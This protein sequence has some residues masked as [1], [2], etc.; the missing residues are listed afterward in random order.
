MGGHRCIS[1][2]RR[3]GLT[4]LNDLKRL[5]PRHY[6]IIDLSLAGMTNVDI[7]TSVGMTPMAIGMVL[8]SPVGQAELTRRRAGIT[9]QVDEGLSS[10]V[11][12][13]KAKLENAAASAADRLIGLLDAQDEAIQRQS[14]KDILDRTFGREGSTNVS[15]TVLSAEK[16]QL[17]TVALREAD[18]LGG[19]IDA[20]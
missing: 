2:A 17:L 19:L 15:V 9:V 5:L 4:T 3:K 18:E 6:R 11:T 16:L 7:A 1:G 13:A 20:D 12:E 10:T 14:A 8:N